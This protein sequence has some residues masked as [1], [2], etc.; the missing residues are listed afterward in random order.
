M[1][2]MSNEKQP[3][4]DE[5]KFV[6]ITKYCQNIE[7]LI[8]DSLMDLNNLKLFREELAFARR[9]RHDR[10][11]IELEKVRWRVSIY[12]NWFWYTQVLRDLCKKIKRDI[13]HKQ[14]LEVVAILNGSHIFDHADISRYILNKQY[15]NMIRKFIFAWVHHEEN[16][17]EKIMQFQQVSIDIAV[18]KLKRNA[19]VNNGILLKLNMKNS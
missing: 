1:S 12:L 7:K 5:K 18:K 15:S 3:V 19:I 17:I 6:Y 13:N 8:I 4:T 11:P 2:Q 9:W 16:T 14:L 10:Q